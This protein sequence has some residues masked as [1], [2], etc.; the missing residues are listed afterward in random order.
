MV[1]FARNHQF[2]WEEARHPLS[3]QVRV[4]PAKKPRVKSADWN[5][6]ETHV[7]PEAWAP[8]FR[9]LW[10]A[11][12]REKIKIWNDIYS[13]YKE[14]F[15]ESQSTVQQ[16]K[17]R[18][19]NLDNEYK[20][21]KQRTRSTREA[22]IQKIKEG[23]PYFYVFDEVMGHRDSIDPSKMAIEGSST[24]TSEPSVNDASQNESESEPPDDVTEVQERKV[25]KNKQEKSGRKGKKRRRDVP[26][27]TTQDWQS[28]FVEMWEKSMEQDNRS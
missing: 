16:V 23:F 3:V 28:S 11:S 19:K 1:L 26:E 13:L 14:R 21:L 10:G 6:D 5:E 9:K 8:T 7:L 22:G 2:H 27:S 15:S 18:Q 12:Q 17:K 4:M 25:E 20:Q 24:F